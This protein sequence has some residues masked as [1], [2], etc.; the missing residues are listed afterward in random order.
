MKEIKLTTTEKLVLSQ[1]SIGNDRE[2]V[3]KTL[4]MSKR[5]VDF[6]MTNIY[7]KTMTNR[8]VSALL[9]TGYIQAVKK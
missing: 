7:E 1:F 6:H 2:Q 9:K 4:E 5:A 8:L 3:A